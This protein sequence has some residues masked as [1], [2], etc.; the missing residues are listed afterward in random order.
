MTLGLIQA[1]AEYKVECPDEISVLSYDDF[2]WAAFFRPQLTAV[3][4]PGLEM[5]RRAAQMLLDTVAAGKGPGREVR[6]GERRT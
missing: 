3:A 1:L 5:G 4:Q 2:P 6:S